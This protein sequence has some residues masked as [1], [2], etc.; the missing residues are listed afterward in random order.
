[1]NEQQID[2]HIKKLEESKQM[3]QEIYDL[4]KVDTSGPSVSDY[5]IKINKSQYQRLLHLL[6]YDQNIEGAISRHLTS[7]IGEWKQFKSKLRK[8]K[9]DY[10]N[11]V[12]KDRTIKINSLLLRLSSTVG[13]IILTIIILNVAYYFKLQVPWIA[14]PK[15]ATSIISNISNPNI[16]TQE[17][18]SH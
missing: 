6:Q 5:S 1:M 15:P 12:K 2:L 10:I 14:S 13:I 16:Q 17:T 4:I 8:L 11:E 9:W 18:K 7:L 3:L